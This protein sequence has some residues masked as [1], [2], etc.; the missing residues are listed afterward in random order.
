MIKML[1]FL[2]AQYKMRHKATEHTRCNVS[3]II[4]Y[5]ISSYQI[6]SVKI[7]ARRFVSIELLNVFL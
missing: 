3:K 1:H 5:Q 6:S 4:C 2:N 7:S